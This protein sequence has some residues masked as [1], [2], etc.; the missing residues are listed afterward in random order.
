MTRIPHI[1]PGDVVGIA[2][3]GVQH[4]GIVSEVGDGGVRVV[5]N[6][7]RR[8]RV[9]EEPIERFAAGRRVVRVGYPGALPPDVVV[10]RARE[11]IGEPWGYVR[12][13]Q[14]FTASVHGAPCRS[15]DADFGA[16]AVFGTLSVVA[17]T[18]RR[19]RGASR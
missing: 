17:I 7:K 2:Y 6:S 5:H 19:Y 18:T 10:A 15:R 16:L 4:Q 12:N 1:E 3:R 14:R 13:C 8:G 11:R 9:V